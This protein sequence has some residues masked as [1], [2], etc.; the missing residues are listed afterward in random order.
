MEKKTSGPL[1]V[2]VVSAIIFIASLMI[3][4]WGH[5]SPTKEK[6]VVSALVVSF[7]AISFAIGKKDDTINY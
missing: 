6:I 5:L 4:F 3:L 7:T 2:I 1:V